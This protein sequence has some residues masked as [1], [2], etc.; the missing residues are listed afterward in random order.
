MTALDTNTIVG[1]FSSQSKAR[2][3]VE[4]LKEAGFSASQ[5]GVAAR[6]THG[7]D[8]AVDISDNPSGTRS[9][10]SATHAAGESMWD[11]IKDFFEGSPEPE[12]Y[13]DEATRGSYKSREVTRE[14]HVYGHEDVRHSLNHLA[15]PEQ[16]SRYFGHQFA[17]GSEGTIVT[18]STSDRQQE[19]RSI[20]QQNGADLGEGAEDF[21]YEGSTPQAL[22]DD[23]NIQL[24]GEVLRVQKNRI[25]RGEVRLRKEVFTDTQ[26]IEVPVTREEIVIER[27]SAS[28]QQAVGNATF[29]EQEIRIPLSEERASVDK[30][31][32]VREN[33]HVGKREVT[34]IQSMDEQV[35][36][37]ELKVDDMTKS[38]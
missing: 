9:S 31:T 21:K 4:A 23:Q 19:A 32:V 27:T 33:V 8:P 20:L 16:H 1:Y 13:A 26:T 5:I 22:A 10:T 36:R 3:A 38:A 18:I 29:D 30:Q 34:N 7:E 28:D 2:Q 35:R 17:Q 14:N 15:I 24:Y 12:P 37:E 6:G 11:K 25:D